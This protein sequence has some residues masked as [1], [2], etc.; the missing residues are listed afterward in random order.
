MEHCKTSVSWPLW[1]FGGLSFFTAVYSWFSGGYQ[2]CFL[3]WWAHAQ[4][5]VMIPLVSIQQEIWCGYFS[6]GI[7]QDPVPFMLFLPLGGPVTCVSRQLLVSSTD[8]TACQI[9]LACAP[10]PW[11]GRKKGPDH[12]DWQDWRSSCSCFV[13]PRASISFC[14]ICW[15]VQADTLSR[16]GQTIPIEAAS[17]CVLCLGGLGRS[18]C[19]PLFPSEAA[20]LHITVPG[21]QTHNVMLVP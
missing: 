14:Y 7:H 15:A 19:L 13:M 6:M 4:A 12:T 21:L 9:S 10:T 16:L 20:R 8:P 17:S 11:M 2:T 1:S 18:T 5:C 3:Y